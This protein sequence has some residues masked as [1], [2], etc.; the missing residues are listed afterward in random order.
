VLLSLLLQGTWAVPVY[1]ACPATV[2]I[3]DQ[4]SCSASLTTFVDHSQAN[5]LGGP[6]SSEECYT[7][8]PPWLNQEQLAP[9]A[10]YTFQ[11][12][13][14][15]N[16]HLNITGMTCDLDIYV[17]DSSCD[18]YAGCVG[19]STEPDADDVVDF[20]CVAGETYYVVIEAYGTAHLGISTNPCTDTGDETGVVYS[21]SYTL[22]FDLSQSSGCNEDCND[23][24]DNDLDGAFDCADPDCGQDPVCCD[25]D[26]DG[27]FGGQCVGGTDCDDSLDTVYPGATELCDQLDN[28]C[29]DVVDDIDADGDGFIADTCGGDDCDDSKA[30]VYP[31]APEDGGMGAG[32]D[33]ID[34]DC[35]GEVDEGTDSVDDDG[36]GYSESDGDCDDSDPAV[37]PGADEIAD[38]GIDD[39]C[40]GET[41]EQAPPLGDDDDTT[42]VGDDD[43]DTGAAGDD[44]DLAAP[45]IFGCDCSV[46]NST[47]P[48][49]LVT[50][51]A[52]SL[53]L[54]LL[55]VAGRRRYSQPS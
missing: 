29:N 8:G 46:G 47:Q 43:D 27:I 32:G 55:A 22:E 23:G 26:D 1:A 24:A 39:D 48:V 4:L 54:S 14:S 6:C 30:N 21:P 17:L 9:E 7:C 16:A 38:N 5:Q 3:I 40:D 11:C 15:G 2:P 36:D 19:G 35:D 37:H 28:D 12:Q 34:N 50:L 52:L 13:A 33:G 45:G 53:L 51:L 42:D 20:P 25:L 49:G 10:V 31:G 41:D 44:D 18:P